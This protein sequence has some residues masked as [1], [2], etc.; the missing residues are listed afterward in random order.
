MASHEDEPAASD[1]TTDAIKR[2]LVA[3]FSVVVGLALICVCLGWLHRR[4]RDQ[5]AA[6]AAAQPVVVAPPRADV[7]AQCVEQGA[8]SPE[9]PPE[10]VPEEFFEVSCV[11]STVF[12]VKP[13]ETLDGADS[14]RQPALPSAVVVGNSE[15]RLCEICCER[16]AEVVLMSCSHGGLCQQCNDEILKR[17]NMHCPHC[18]GKVD[19]V[20][21]LEAPELL[22][23]GRSCKARRIR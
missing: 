15:E 2:V 16:P 23:Q 5:Q 18:R 21:L 9:Q 19:K 6:A 22:S 11:S 12:T 14:A 1:A 7:E 20:I 17:S 8:A 3:V 10:P 13:L 4:K